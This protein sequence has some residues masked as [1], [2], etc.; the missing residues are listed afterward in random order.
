MTQSTLI[1]YD[2]YEIHG[3]KDFGDFTEQVPDDEAEFWSLYG[4]IPGQGVECIGDF[5]SRH[6]AEEVLERI[7]GWTISQNLNTHKKENLL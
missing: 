6:H 7:T 5:T 1:P 4:H 2:D 3:C